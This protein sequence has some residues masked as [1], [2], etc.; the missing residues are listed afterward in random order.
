MSLRSLG[1]QACNN[2]QKIAV[3]F[4]V[5]TIDFTLLQKVTTTLKPTQLPTQQLTEEERGGGFLV[6]RGI[7]A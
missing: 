1:V 4:P 6:G 2:V 3:R 5:G 7:V